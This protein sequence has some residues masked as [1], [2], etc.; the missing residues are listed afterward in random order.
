ML[1]DD[2]KLGWCFKFL[3]PEPL[4][5][6]RICGQLHYIPRVM[7]N[8]ILQHEYTMKRTPNDVD[9]GIEHCISLT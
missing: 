1:K 6:P 2:D 4:T 7:E 8:A 9:V 5:V 3:I